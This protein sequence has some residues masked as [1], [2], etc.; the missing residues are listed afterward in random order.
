[1]ATLILQLA[2]LLRSVVSQRAA[3][4]QD[5]GCN[6]SY[7]L[8]S[9][10]WQK[11]L[12]GS[13]YRVYWLNNTGG[14]TGSYLDAE[15]NPRLDQPGPGLM[16]TF[17]TEF[18]TKNNIN[19]N[20][21]FIEFTPHELDQ[22]AAVK[23]A[24]GLEDDN[25][26]FA[27][28]TAA[29]GLGIVDICAGITN[30]VRQST[31]LAPFFPSHHSD[32]VYLHVKKGVKTASIR[33]TLAAIFRPF[34]GYVW[35]LI[36]AAGA[37]FG[38]ALVWLER[39][40]GG[41]NG[42][43]L[44]VR[45]SIYFTYFGFMAGVS[46]E[47]TKTWG[48]RFANVGFAFL[49]TTLVASYTANLASF[50]SLPPQIT[51]ITGIEQLARS[52]SLG[53]LCVQFPFQGDFILQIFP[54][55][56]GRIRWVSNAT[57]LILQVQR[58][59]CAGAYAIESLL[60][61]LQSIGEACGV[62]QLIG[63]AY[64]TKLQIS[65]PVSPQAQ[66]TLR[67]QFAA[68]IVIDQDFA[69]LLEAYRPGSTCDDKTAS[70]GQEGVE[71]SLSVNDLSGAFLVA[72]I[73]LVCGLA[74]NVIERGVRSKERDRRLQLLKWSEKKRARETTTKTMRAG[75]SRD[76]QQGRLAD[77][78]VP[79]DVALARSKADSG[80]PTEE[81]EGFGL[82]AA[83]SAQL[84]QL[85]D[86]GFSQLLAPD[87]QPPDRGELREEVMYAELAK[88]HVKLDELMAKVE[89]QSSHR[90]GSRLVQDVQDA[91]LA[92]E[93]AAAMVT[94]VAGEE[95]HEQSKVWV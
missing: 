18:A 74:L 47:V 31:P 88:M 15:G 2:L 77:A 8:T 57:D 9:L 6:L 22:I 44:G 45:E 69:H 72:F 92:E 61:P 67:Q 85:A 34:T 39:G 87:P 25:S 73:C 27:N 33:E 7:A 50:L 42:V 17:L 94:P 75:S 79:P 81:G 38:T 91:Q 65:M 28:C 12:A 51:G 10:E 86:L 59:E 36:G 71:Q 54:E 32:G 16:R 20:Q 63:G 40:D 56:R 48:G 70:T 26:I 5:S 30:P 62:F 29:A 37:V 78:D 64:N 55:L 93:D 11:S 53:E 60:E 66:F 23:A 43:G 76:H 3:V 35:A 24:V 14:W 90:P 84:A 21:N 1:M 89:G 80:K 41:F 4:S 49:V 46:P 95:M 83:A 82:A 58:G 13:A 52:P 68:S 19:I